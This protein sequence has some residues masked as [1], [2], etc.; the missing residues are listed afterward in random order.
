MRTP[1]GPPK[2]PSD[3]KRTWDEH[4]QKTHRVRHVR[5]P[6]PLDSE[7]TDGF[8]S[9]RKAQI[10]DTVATIPAGVNF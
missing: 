5:P 6:P 10:L 7:G 2:D 9:S 8:G 3:Q 1:P 4:R